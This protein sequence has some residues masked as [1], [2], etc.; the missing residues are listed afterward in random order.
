MVLL[1]F[2]F[3]ALPPQVVGKTTSILQK[4]KTM[5]DG[6]VAKFVRSL[7]EGKKHAT[8]IFQNYTK[9]G[10]PM[11]NHAEVYCISRDESAIFSN[12]LYLGFFSTHKRRFTAAAMQ[13]RC[14]VRKNPAFGAKQMDAV[15][16]D[17]KEKH[18]ETESRRDEQ[19]VQQ[20]SSHSFQ[21]GSPKKRRRSNTMS[22][23]MV[24]STSSS[25]SSSSSYMSAALHEKICLQLRRDSTDER[26]VL[27]ERLPCLILSA[28]E[29]D[30]YIQ[31]L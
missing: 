29:S 25:S 7:K 6:T 2:L 4:P 19:I 15:A 3:F 31:N 28:T 17:I 18:E 20:D 11:D 27:K 14:V 23:T 21:Q 24:S 10:I 12:R 1:F 16:E 30:T 9:K 26:P 22:P 13:Q 8:C 5:E